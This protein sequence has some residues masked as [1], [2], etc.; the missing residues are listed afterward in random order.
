M[1]RIKRGKFDSVARAFFVIIFL[2]L[3]I[4]PITASAKAI[5]PRG[6]DRD[7]GKEIVVSEPLG[8]PISVRSFSYIAGSIES[9]PEM[10]IIR[11]KPYN[12][13]WRFWKSLPAT[14]TISVSN[15]PKDAD[16]YV[17]TNGYREQIISRTT[18][19][20]TLTLSFSS[21]VG[22][23]F[24]VKSS[25]STKH[26]Y[27][28]GLLRPAG[29]DCSSIGAWNETTLICTLNK[30]VT[31]TIAIEDNDITLDGEGHNL[32]GA[33]TGDGV[34][35]DV[36]NFTV[37]NLSISNF[38]RGVVYTAPLSLQTIPTGDKI[39]DLSL[40]N[41]AR[42]V[43]IEGI[44]ETRISNVEINGGN[45][46]IFLT[47]KNLDGF[48]TY[49]ISIKNSTIRNTDLALYVSEVSPTTFTRNNVISNTTDLSLNSATLL[50]TTPTDRGNFWSKF[51]N[52]IQ[53]IANPNYC[54]NSYNT[55]GE[56]DSRP[57]ACENGWVAGVN[58]PV[59]S[60]GGTPTVIHKV[61]LYTQI[62]S[63]YPNENDTLEWSKD[64]Y[65]FASPL[66]N[67]RY[68]CGFS[69]G[70]CGCALVSG[71]MVIKYF[72]P[73]I[74]VN[75]RILNDHLKNPPTNPLTGVKYD[76]YAKDGGF[77]YITGVNIFSGGKIKFHAE[78]FGFDLANNYAFLDAHL[79]SGGIAFGRALKFRNG[80]Y[81]VI[82]K[83]VGSNY[84][85]R[86]PW[87]F[88]NDYLNEDLVGNPRPLYNNK[89]TAF[90]YEGKF[91]AL[92][93]YSRGNGLQSFL[94]IYF[95][96]PVE[97]VIIDPQ[98]RRLGINPQSG[99]TFREISTGRYSHESIGN[100]DPL[101]PIPTNEERKEVYINN[102]IDGEYRI[103]AYGTNDGSFTLSVDAVAGGGTY[104]DLLSGNIK[105]GE[106]RTYFF[107]LRGGS[108]NNITLSTSSLSTNDGKVVIC[109]IPPGNPSNKHTITISRSALKAHLA[110][111]DTIGLC[112]N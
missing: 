68:G 42:N 104:H 102:P 3:A 71:V 12:P 23:Q 1:T 7:K 24:I 98:G 51:T 73:S 99:Q 63:P 46:G 86:D 64:P 97:F 70:D 58:C 48:P 36:A 35:A 22:A 31:E 78:S 43:M 79:A 16:L 56:N 89:P 29:G 9:L 75:P 53:D 38:A 27:I 105:S 25:P 44:S 32:T 95:A 76:G 2:L 77:Q 39:T 26:I 106:I 28:G 50:L 111:G 57:W 90:D 34:Y 19:D 5:H 107:R 80:H 110:H 33:G 82:E 8:W 60:G 14:T 65:A 112:T 92:Y 30:N 54:T 13:W 47:D 67:T 88:N 62:Q 37:K 83:K 15:L 91:D 96:S 59:G 18:Q 84:L 21:K 101:V 55:G 72:E 108:T 49:D 69:I 94:H 17:Y 81:F 52:C 66:T 40:S 109:H 100:P 103:E 41:I 87:F 11:L 61:P 85:I 4:A 20:G 6:Y 45:T 10:A 93:S 74:S